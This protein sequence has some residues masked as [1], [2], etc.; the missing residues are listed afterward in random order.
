MFFPPSHSPFSL[1][2]F[3]LEINPVAKFLELLIYLLLLILFSAHLGYVWLT[4]ENRTPTLFNSYRYFSFLFFSGGLGFYRYDSETIG[5]ISLTTSAT[6]IIV[7]LVIT[8][9]H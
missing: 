1:K 8:V 6:L 3:I 5:A 9:V 2:I 7:V 4:V